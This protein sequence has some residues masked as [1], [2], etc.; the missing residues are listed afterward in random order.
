MAIPKI[1][2][3]ETEYG[4]IGRHDPDFDPISRTLLLI[5]SYQTDVPFPS[6]WDYARESSR[7]DPQAIA[8]DDIYDIPDSSDPLT[9][10]KVLTNGARFYLDHAHPEY[11]TPECAN[12]RDLVCYEKAGERILDHSRRAA[13]QALAA[14][15][16][17]LLYKNNSDHKGNSYGYHENYLLDRNTPFR[18]IVE[19]FTAF[20][21][22]RQI[23]CGAG[24]VGAE[25]GAD[26]TAYQLSQR[27]DFF[28]TEVGLDTMVK[29]P[30]INTRD[31]PH[32]NRERYRRLHVILGDANM[33]EYTS[34]LKLG[35]TAIV[36]GMIE[37]QFIPHA[38]TLR[39]PVAALKAIS[40][41]LT[42][43]KPVELD[44]GG[45]ITPVD[46][47]WEYW[48]LAERYVR[49][50]QVEPWV[51]DVLWKW[52]HVLRHLACDPL[53][54]VNELDWV[55]KWRLLTSYMDRHGQDWT[56]PRI[57]M[58]DIQYHD[59]RGDRGLYYMLERRG[60]VQRLL[61]DQEIDL[62]VEDPPVDTRAYL[63]GMCLKKFR[64]QV[65][66]VNWDSLA[67]NLEEGE[68]RRIALEDPFQGTKAQ[69][70]E[71]IE[72]ARSATEFVAA[73]P[74]T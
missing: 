59:I 46:L 65:F 39:D 7:Y 16:Q 28:E 15:Q 47:Q 20:L 60:E 10:N 68:I 34:Y 14:G 1:L 45:T 57:A 31:E 5:N 51:E 49:A 21:V 71:A 72:A 56:N 12:V 23:F 26:P 27:A 30:L 53:A 19:Q 18:L 36:L 52:E 73:L 69:I 40:R 43:R 6:L 37:D 32:A 29:R 8:L 66:S 55:I 38:L 48:R 42:C 67:F 61:T 2:G 58:L 63:R 44:T 62:A 24:K 25:N 70:A 64:H 17:I 3:T 9:I 11:A 50:F 54:L 13:E 4:I 35:T 22:S 74:E 41:D 33:S